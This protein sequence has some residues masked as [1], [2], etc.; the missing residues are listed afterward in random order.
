[1]INRCYAPEIQALRIVLL[2]FLVLP[3]LRLSHAFFLVINTLVIAVLIVGCEISVD[4]FRTNDR[5]VFI[6][7]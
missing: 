6:A 4:A 7:C 1:M 3:I 5:P 2:K